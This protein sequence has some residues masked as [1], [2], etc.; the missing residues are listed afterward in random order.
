MSEVAGAAH[1][2][3]KDTPF[4]VADGYFEC[5]STYPSHPTKFQPTRNVESVPS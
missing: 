5:R 4:S 1:R 2:I 3:A